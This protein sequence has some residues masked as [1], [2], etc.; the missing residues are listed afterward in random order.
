MW[1]LDGLVCRQRGLLKVDVEG[2]LLPA[3][4]VVPIH[5]QSQTNQYSPQNS[6]RA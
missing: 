3:Q 1:K 2:H 6:P 4:C 5:T